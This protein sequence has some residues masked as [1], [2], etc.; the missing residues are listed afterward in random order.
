[1]VLVVATRPL[2]AAVTTLARAVDV[3]ALLV[4]AA[5]LRPTTPKSP[6][7]CQ[8]WVSKDVTLSDAAFTKNWSPVTNTP[9]RN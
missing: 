9:F 5:V 8:V 2:V 3:V 1:M 6:E 4:V 7:Q